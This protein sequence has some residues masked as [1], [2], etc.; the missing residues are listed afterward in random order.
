MKHAGRVARS[1]LN[2]HCV[3][4]EQLIIHDQLSSDQEPMNL[5]LRNVE[6]FEFVNMVCFLYCRKSY[7]NLDPVYA[8]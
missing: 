2:H 8:T 4:Q 7:T 3:K 1:K 6:G 5:N